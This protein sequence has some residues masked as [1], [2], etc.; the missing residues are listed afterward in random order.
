MNASAFAALI[1]AA[2]KGTRMKSALPKV[3]H[4]VA[5]RPMIGHVLRAVA[6]LGAARERVVV[7]GPGMDDGARRRSR[8]PRPPS[9]PSRSAPRDAVAG[10]ARRRWP[11]SPATCWCSMATRR[12][13]PPRPW[14]GCWPSGGGRPA[15]AVVVL[16]MR[17]AEPGAYGRLIVGA[18]GTLDAIVEAADCDARASA[19]SACAIPA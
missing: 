4:R 10:R 12:W 13:S 15:P 18:D 14:S 8:R 6:P 9:R 16:G 19:P 2:G 17:P 11:A 1:L 3:L 7:I 5:D